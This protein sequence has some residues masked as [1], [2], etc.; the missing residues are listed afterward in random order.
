V[1]E[2]LDSARHRDTSAERGAKAPVT[3]CLDR[4][5]VEGRCHTTGQPHA[6]DISFAIYIDVHRDIAA[7][8]AGS[9][10]LWVRRLLLFQHLR[11]LDSGCFRVL[12]VGDGLCCYQG[13]EYKQR[14]QTV[15]E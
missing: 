12:S 5:P 1:K 10:F 9:S 11:W 8:A 15:F 2:K 14:T 7:H 6:R 4:G 3:G 13:A